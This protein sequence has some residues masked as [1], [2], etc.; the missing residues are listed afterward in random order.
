MLNFEDKSIM[1]P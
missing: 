1:K